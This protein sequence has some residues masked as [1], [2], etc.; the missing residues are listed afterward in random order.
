MNSQLEGLAIQ[1]LLLLILFLF[2]A[3]LITTTLVA[4][5]YRLHMETYLRC[6]S[7]KK[8]QSSFSGSNMLLFSKFLCGI[9]FK[10]V[11]LDSWSGVWGTAVYKDRFLIGAILRT[12]LTCK[13]T[14]IR[15][16][17]HNTKLSIYLYHGGLLHID[18]SLKW[19]G[20]FTFSSDI[21]ES[22]HY[23]DLSMNQLTGLIPTGALSKNITTM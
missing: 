1:C 9:M 2:P 5:Q 11:W 13:Q 10:M 3:N 12:F 16:W 4:I 14:S 6:W 23:R 18:T 19:E 17:C 22:W 8:I 20:L 7:C 21:M 15:N